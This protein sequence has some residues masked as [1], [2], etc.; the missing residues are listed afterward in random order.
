MTVQLS[1]HLIELLKQSCEGYDIPETQEQIEAM[2]TEIL[3]AWIFKQ[4]VS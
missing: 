2:I 1:D 3:K 4:S